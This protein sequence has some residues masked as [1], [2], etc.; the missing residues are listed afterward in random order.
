MNSGEQRSRPGLVL[1]LLLLAGVSVTGC[2]RNSDSD[3]ERYGQ[4]A[5]PASSGAGESQFGARFDQAARAAPNSEP[6]NVVD[7]DMP[8]VDPTKEPVEVP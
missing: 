8:P 7:G 1:G 5:P 3:S 6:M 4:L 2:G